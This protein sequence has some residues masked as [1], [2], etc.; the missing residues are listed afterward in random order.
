VPLALRALFACA[1]AALAVAAWAASGASEDELRALRARIDKLQRDLSAA[2][3]TRGEAADQL[4]ASEKAM[5]EAQRALY[6]LSRE[7]RSIEAQLESVMS[8]ERE[9][10][11][12]QAEQEALAGRL[13]RL[14]YRQ[15]A[16]DRL[17]LIL[18]GRDAASVARHIAYYGYIQRARAALIGDLRRQGESLAELEREAVARRAELAQNESA[19]QSEAARLQKERSARAA[20]VARISGDIAKGRR[21]IGRLKRDEERLARL[22]DRIAKA[23]AAPTVPG[24][25]KRVDRVPDASVSSQPFERLKGRLQLP[26]K[27]EL[28]N[29][30]G[31]AREEGA[32]WKGLFIRSVSGETIHAVADGRVVYAD[33]LRGF[34]NLLILDH[35]KGYM[36]LYA[37]NEALLFQVGEKV[38]GGDPIA[39]VGAS[40]GQS[41]SGLYFELRRDGKPFDPLKWV[42]P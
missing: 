26:V 8:R 28:T 4:K 22:V 38:R 12:G 9:A 17:R 20:V 2:E 11:N 25:G 23:L 36:S 7:R 19:Q 10:R 41:D 6:S 16:P 40:G 1:L 34:G 35:G 18:E 13:L 42:A 29:Q 24:K 37:N 39:R 32:S 14:Q 15:G 30:Y 3:E 27:G 21:E 31:A 33:W 5:S